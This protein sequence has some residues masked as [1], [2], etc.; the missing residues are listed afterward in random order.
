[1][2]PKAELWPATVTVVVGLF[3]FVSWVIGW[4]FGTTLGAGNASMKMTTALGFVSAGCAVLAHRHMD[5]V[6]VGNLVAFA[7]AINLIVWFSSAF[8]SVFQ[9]APPIVVLN[10]A[11]TSAETVIPHV[12][13]L[14]TALCFLVFAFHKVSVILTGRSRATTTRITLT[15]FG[16]SS[17]AGYVLEIPFLYFYFE[18]ISTAMAVH[19]A[20]GMLLLARSLREDYPDAHRLESA[21]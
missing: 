1:M 6:R 19:T 4:E 13:S 14:A 20:V 2:H 5:S 21:A 15:F 9:W 10:Q 18:E 7:C 17:L 11:D 3:V 16:L 12:P 8:L